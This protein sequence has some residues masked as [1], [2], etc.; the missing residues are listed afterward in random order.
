MKLTRM[1]AE[2]LA[3]LATDVG[4]LTA[5]ITE[6][7]LERPRGTWVPRKRGEIGVA[8]QVKGAIGTLRKKLA[9]ALR[10]PQRPSPVAHP[11][12]PGPRRRK[13]LSARRR[14]ASAGME[15]RAR[16]RRPVAAQRT[17]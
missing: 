11:A 12:P 4:T 17:S 9:K 1:E 6:D 8:A 16:A 14:L 3:C 15:R 13:A 2:V 7:L 5:D 10:A